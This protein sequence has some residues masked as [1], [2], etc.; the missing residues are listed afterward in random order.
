MTWLATPTR[1]PPRCS[2]MP[3]TCGSAAILASDLHV[4]DLRVGRCRPCGAH[5]CARPL[6]QR[7]RALELLLGSKTE[8]STRQA[9]N[10][11]MVYTETQP[12]CAYTPVGQ[13]NAS[14]VEPG[15]NVSLTLWS[16]DCSTLSITILTKLRTNPSKNSAGGR[17]LKAPAGEPHQRLEPPRHCQPVCPGS[18]L[19]FSRGFSRFN[20]VP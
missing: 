10:K 2:A 12:Y 6:R 16:S 15:R 13:S 9:L 5:D 7:H 8:E 14:Y 18:L 19:S 4:H 17:T 20:F 1:M 3:R 11:I